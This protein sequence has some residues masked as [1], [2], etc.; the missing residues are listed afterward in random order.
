M[1][2]LPYP[3]PFDA[4]DS[5][6]LYYIQNREAIG[7]AREKEKYSARVTDESPFDF[8]QLGTA[9]RAVAGDRNAMNNHLHIVRSR[10]GT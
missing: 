8:Y 10:A 3:H 6:V 1:T 4:I 7:T 5:D 9:A 2:Y